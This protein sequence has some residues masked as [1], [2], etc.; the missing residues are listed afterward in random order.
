V[1]PL[2]GP[3]EVGMRALVLLTE[4]FPRQLDA[5]QLV[6]LEHAMLHSG[7]LDGPSSLHPEL[8]ASP[9]ELGM[10]RRLIEQGLVVLM[11]A[12][13]ASMTAT[14][15]GFLYVATE[16]APGFIE[17]LESPYVHQLRERAAWLTEVYAPEGTD[18]REGMRQITQRWSERFNASA[19]GGGEDEGP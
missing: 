7:D 8:P 6:Y 16:E 5:A 3:L 12:G 18:V 4:A 15:S 1:N 11:R 19:L 2:N 13:L 9:G 17:V 14:E 10:R